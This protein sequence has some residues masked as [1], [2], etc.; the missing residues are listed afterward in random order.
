VDINSLIQLLGYPGISFFMFS[1]F[2][3]PLG[4][5]VPGDSML[6][7]T[8]LLSSEDIFN[9]WVMLVILP[10]LSFCGDLTGFIFGRLVGPSVFEHT[11]SRL[12]KK[13]N[14]QKAKK[15][16]DE[17]GSKKLVLVKFVPII[18]TFIPTVAG[19]TGMKKRVFVT[20]SIFSSLI[21]IWGLLLGGYFLG[22]IIPNLEHHLLPVTMLVL[23]ASL[24]PA[25]WERRR[26]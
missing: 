19:A 24:I 8:G 10:F 3:S 21:W 25:F 18:R 15:Y 23:I 16:L 5:V 7:V 2:A 20:L 12:L 17:N 14:L 26:K 1:L 4:V 6:V 22:S 11:H 13:R 9:I